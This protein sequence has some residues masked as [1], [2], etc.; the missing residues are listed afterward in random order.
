MKP[1]KDV[2]WLISP[3]ALA[4]YTQDG[5]VVLDIPKRICYSLD[6]VASRIWLA[7]ESSPSGITVEGIVG[8]L[9]QSFEIRRE[10]IASDASEFLDNLHRMSLVR[11]QYVS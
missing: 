9:E 7:M 4:T 3:D 10:Q 11:C 5:A 8:V 6:A 2:V 1:D